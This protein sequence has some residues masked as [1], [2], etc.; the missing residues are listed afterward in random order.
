MSDRW[1]INISYAHKI[2]DQYPVEVIERT[3]KSLIVQFLSTGSI[4]IFDHAMICELPFNK[5]ARRL[6]RTEAIAHWSKKQKI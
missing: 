4:A 6:S 2:E 1:F 5:K 3:D